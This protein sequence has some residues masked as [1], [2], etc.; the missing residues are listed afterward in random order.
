MFGVLFIISQLEE[1]HICSEVYNRAH[2]NNQLRL[3]RSYMGLI[4]AFFEY[5]LYVV[6]LT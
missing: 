5:F 4:R 3:Q 1:N 2:Q 6:P